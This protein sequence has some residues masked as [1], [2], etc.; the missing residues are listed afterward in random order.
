MTLIGG[1]ELQLTEATTL[2]TRAV[3]AGGDLALE[4]APSPG[5]MSVSVDAELNQGV[6]KAR[7]TVAVSD[8]DAQVAAETVVALQFAASGDAALS[9]GWPEE[10]IYEYVDLVWSHIREPLQRA[11]F[12]VGKDLSLRAV[13][14]PKL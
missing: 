4:W 1:V 11:A 10:N 12:S 8:P 7:T 13:P 9:A 3:D 5:Q 2:S 14:K 6:L